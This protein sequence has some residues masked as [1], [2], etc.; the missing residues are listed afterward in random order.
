MLW[1]ASLLLSTA[2][3]VSTQLAFPSYA[4]R[5]MAATG[6]TALTPLSGMSPYNADCGERFDTFGPPTNVRPGAFV[7]GNAEVEPWIAVSPASSRPQTVNLIAVWQQDRWSDAGARG[8]VASTSAD[9]GRSWKRTLLPF[10]SCSPGGPSYN[11]ASDPWVSVGPDGLTYATALVWNSQTAPGGIGTIVSSDGGKT[12]ERFHLV[13]QDD[14]YESDDKE[15]ITADPTRPG[16]AYLVWDRTIWPT[17]RIGDVGYFSRTV[18]GGE[19]WSAPRPITALRGNT[20][21]HQIVVNPRNDLLYDFYVFSDEQHSGLCPG[22]DRACGT[23]EVRYVLSRDGG[24]NWSNPHIVAKGRVFQESSIAGCRVRTGESVPQV[25]IDPQTDALNVVWEDRG[26]APGGN[27]HVV[28]SRS[29]D[30]GVHWS[31]PKRVDGPNA[32]AAFTPTIAINRTG[33]IAVAYYRS[34]AIHCGGNLPTEYWIGFSNDHGMTFGNRRRIATSFN[35]LIAPQSAGFF[36]GDYQGLVSAGE[37][38]HPVFVTTNPQQVDNPTDV[39]TT[40]LAGPGG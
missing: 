28:I 12:W 6:P 21:G 31:A 24:L 32:R 1:K 18:N 19:T 7:Y 11:Q 13:S 2:V 34:Q 20:I 14:R 3:L 35:L 39:F 16:T 37:R 10:T 15:T 38:F 26:V 30:G 23:G 40:T 17:E 25:A 8:I 9:D 22:G 5:A 36:L 29:L 4:P 27:D 33:V